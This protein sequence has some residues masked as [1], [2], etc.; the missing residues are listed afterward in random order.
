MEEV[1]YSVGDILG[2][3]SEIISRGQNGH[4]GAKSE[5]NFEGRNE[6]LGGKS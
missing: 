2:I 3:K 1:S 5:V 6:T 4:F